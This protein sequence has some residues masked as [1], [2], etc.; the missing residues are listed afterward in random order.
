MKCGKNNAY[1]A[2]SSS[3]IG[4]YKVYEHPEY[5]YNKVDD[6]ENKIFS[7]GSVTTVQ[8]VETKMMCRFCGHT[9]FIRNE[10]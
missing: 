2:E 9:K 6:M 7:S 1:T 4:E 3:I 8:L 5:S 10:L